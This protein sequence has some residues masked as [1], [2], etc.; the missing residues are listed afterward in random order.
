[1]TLPPLS[2][3]QLQKV[4][5]EAPTNDA[6]YD[7]LSLYEDEVC[8]QFTPSTI[9][10]DTELLSAFYASLLFSLLLINEM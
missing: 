4:L 9:N 8:Q 1:M 5:T 6:M 3:P 7:I 10:G 2:L